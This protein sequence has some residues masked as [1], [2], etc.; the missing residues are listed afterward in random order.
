MSIPYRPVKILALLVSTLLLA[1]CQSA[2]PP[3]NCAQA[4]D[5]C[6]RFSILHTND[7]HGRFWR[8][9][10]DEYGMAARKTLIDAQRAQIAA[11]GGQ[12]LLL[13]GGDINIGVP[14]SDMQDAVPD[15]IG[16][17]L[18]G[19]DAMAV[20]NHEFDSDMSVLEMQRQL[21]EFPMLAA[22]IFKRDATRSVTAEHYFAP[23]RIFKLNGVTLA[24]VGMTTKD[25]AHLVHP[26]NVDAVYFADPIEVMPSVLKEIR[27][28]HPDV[29][30]V[31]GLT[32]MGHYADGN[33]GSEAPGDVKMARALPPGQLHGIIGGHSQ[34]PVCMEPGSNQYADFKPGDECVPD[35]QNGTWIMQAYE[36]G[37]YV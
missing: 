30:L 27:E 29:Q 13:S 12:S 22:N 5:E 17:N 2:V 23:Y 9:K 10:Y 34:N 3:Q 18:I 35:Q 8:N 7:H 36:W 33:H 4:G 19:Y 1:G 6:V 32:H 15:F 25:T 21:A 20:G 37:K 28:D 26:D 24:V 16:M 11:A 31:F 14:E